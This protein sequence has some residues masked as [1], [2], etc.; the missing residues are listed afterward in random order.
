MFLEEGVLSRANTEVLGW[1]WGTAPCSG[2]LRLV[3]KRDRSAHNENPVH[4]CSHRR[5]RK[6]NQFLGEL[7]RAVVCEGRK[8]SSGATKDRT[9]IGSALTVVSPVPKA[10]PST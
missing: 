2:I 1:G 9:V 7:V 3:E 6:T 5:K 10:V 4:G 8:K